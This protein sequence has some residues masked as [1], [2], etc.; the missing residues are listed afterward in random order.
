MPIPFGLSQVNQAQ[1]LSWGDVGSAEQDAVYFN[2]GQFIIDARNGL[3]FPGAAGI[4]NLIDKGG[5][6]FNVKAYGVKGNP[7]TD[8][9]AAIQAA[10]NA[11]GVNGGI[12]YFPPGTY[13]INAGLTIS[14]PNVMLQGAG[15]NTS[16]IIVGSV[17]MAAMLTC[18]ATRQTIRDLQLS[19]NTF[20][21]NCIQVGANASSHKIQNCRLVNSS[22]APV[23]YTATDGS[24]SFT[25]IDGCSL[26]PNTPT[27]TV[28]VQFDS[29]APAS[30]NNRWLINSF[31]P[32]GI[33]CDVAQVNE[34]MMYGN[35]C[36]QIQFSSQSAT[37]VQC[38]NNRITGQ[39][40]GSLGPG[41]SL[42][43]N[44]SQF[45]N[46]MMSTGPITITN[47]ATHWEVS[48][49]RGMHVTDSNST[50]ASNTI[51]D[52]YEDGT[53]TYVLPANVQVIGSNARIGYGTSAGGAI[54]QQTNKST[55]VTL[56]TPCGQITM[57]NAALNSATSVGFTLT[58]SVIAATDVVFVSIAS[59][60][61]A[62]S[63][64]VT[65]DAVAG[66]SCHIQLRNVSG[67]SL[68]E[69]VV[70]NFVVIKAVSS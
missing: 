42:M 63:Y 55:G 48:G 65:V 37:K 31:A 66:G 61:T 45:M 13:F 68:S 51:L 4:T 40:V 70:L 9:S 15:A 64:A 17:V 11:A 27:T 50:L 25:V 24:N 38:N 67:G 56:N 8:D 41:V 3:F 2:G 44:Y 14:S 26:E 30:G 16:V 62:N 69:A 49:N 5:Q 58:N 19:G 39:T 20:A 32:G 6:V 57:N 47:G 35:M 28:G 60:A 46:N 29:S 54:T 53:T 23:S 21:V 22:G 52:G 1:G 18:T 34:L 43:G 36:S 10:I 7:S 12:V 59:A 33:I